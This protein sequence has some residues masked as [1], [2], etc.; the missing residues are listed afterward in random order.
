MTGARL[1]A[2]PGKPAKLI[3][4]ALPDDGTDK[5]LLHALRKEK[6]V[7]RADSIYARGVAI[8]RE[9]EARKGKLPEPSLVR[10][11]TVIVDAEEADELF[12]L[13]YERA[14]IGR[15]D[16]GAIAL[17]TLAFATP[18]ELPEGLPEEGSGAPA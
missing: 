15:P 14:N 6:G 13:I 4:C 18:Y 16:G 1:P 10:L 5:R 3:W 11:V 2:V 17:A 7:T 12:D 8:L 9:A